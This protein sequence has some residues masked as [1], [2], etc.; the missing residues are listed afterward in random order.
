M[1][2]NSFVMWGTLSLMMLGAAGGAIY[3]GDLFQNFRDAYPSDMF[4]QDARRRCGMMDA[5]FSKFSSGDRANCYR[6]QLR[7]PDT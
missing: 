3:R 2:Y 1:S 7:M 5:S 4:K 6:T